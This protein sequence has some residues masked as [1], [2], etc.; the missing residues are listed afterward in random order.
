M[1]GFRVAKKTQNYPD[2]TPDGVLGE[3]RFKSRDAHPRQGD[4]GP[5]PQAHTEKY[6]RAQNFTDCGAAQGNQFAP[7]LLAA[8]SYRICS[9]MR[10]I[11]NSENNLFLDAFKT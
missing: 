2:L 9:R 11:S 7:K 1:F 10:P 3:R 8:Q 4:Q 5:R 6:L